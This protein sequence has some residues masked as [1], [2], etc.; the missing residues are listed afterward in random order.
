MS[1]RRKEQDYFNEA[2]SNFM[3]DMASGGAIRHLADRGYRARQS[4]DHDHFGGHGGSPHRGHC[5][6]SPRSEEDKDVL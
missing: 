5:G 3:F 6:L 4:V 2:L 1:D